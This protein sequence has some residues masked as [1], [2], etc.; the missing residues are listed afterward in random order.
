MSRRTA[1]GVLCISAL[2]ASAFGGEAPAKKAKT[3]RRKRRP[4]PAM[5]PIEDVAGLPRVL[6]IGDSIS[7]GYTL[8]T[9]KLLEGKANLH[10]ALT[11]CGPTSKGVQH[12]DKWLTGRPK[13]QVKGGLDIVN[14]L[15]GNMI[16]LRGVYQSSEYVDQENTITSPGWSEF[17]AKVNQDVAECCTVFLGVD[18]IF[19][20]H[21][22]P[23]NVNDFRPSIGRYIYIGIRSSF[24]ISK[25]QH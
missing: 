14:V 7:I 10:R 22:N 23:N 11:N 21:R 9:R 12:L 24:Q 25:T 15:P 18:N 5:K 3:K 16:N 19:D 13:N 6:L 4:N 2:A 20:D 1:I 8:P 17:D